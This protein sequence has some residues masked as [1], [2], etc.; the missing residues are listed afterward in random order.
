[1]TDLSQATWRKSSHSNGANTGCVEVATNLLRW[2]AVRD[3][4]DPDGGAQIMERSEFFA[5]IQAVKA[6][7]YDL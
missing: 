1:M 3:S 4:K 5:F 7:R 2:A 6:G